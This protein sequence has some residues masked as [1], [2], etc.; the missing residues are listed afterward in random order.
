M[1][2]I[3]IDEGTLDN[4]LAAELRTQCSGNLECNRVMAALHCGKSKL[5]SL[6]S[7]GN[8]ECVDWVTGGR[9]EITGESYFEYMQGLT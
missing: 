4:W 8:L 3:E 6:V 9:D 1:P 5:M 2:T 7:A